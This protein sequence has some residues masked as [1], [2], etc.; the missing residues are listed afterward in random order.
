MESTSK[1]NCIQVSQQTADLL[2]ASEKGYWLTEREDTVNAK[3]KGELRTYWLNREST[4]NTSEKTFHS[5][6]EHFNK[7]DVLSLSQSERLTI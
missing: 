4:R 7:R 3:G 1:E 6:S 5:I 2:I